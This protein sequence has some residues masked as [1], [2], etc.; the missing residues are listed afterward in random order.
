[1]KALLIIGTIPLWP[2][3][4]IVGIPYGAVLCMRRLQGS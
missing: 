2:L 3:L 1:M 4:L